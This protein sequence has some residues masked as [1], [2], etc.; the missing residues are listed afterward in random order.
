[1]IT[2]INGI[3]KVPALPVSVGINLIMELALR[4]IL[5]A[6]IPIQTELVLAVTMD[7]FWIMDLASLSQNLPILPY[8]TLSAA[9][10]D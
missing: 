8:T 6:R 5:F 7:T 3:L 2:A 4:S 10:K 1:M 9:L